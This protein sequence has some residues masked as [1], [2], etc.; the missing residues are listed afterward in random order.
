MFLWICRTWKGGEQTVPSL[1][2]V[3]PTV[4]ESGRMGRTLRIRRFSSR[5]TLGD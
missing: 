4:V 1:E 2:S 3:R 5:Q